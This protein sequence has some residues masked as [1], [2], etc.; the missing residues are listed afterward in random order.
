[1]KIKK[2]IKLKT[3]RFTRNQNVDLKIRAISSQTPNN[4]Y[5]TNKKENKEDE[6]FDWTNYESIY[7][8]LISYINLMIIDLS[9]EKEKLCE[10]LKDIFHAVFKISQEIKKKKQVIDNIK[11][12]DNNIDINNKQNSTHEEWNFLTGEIFYKKNN[13][14][15]INEKNNIKQLFEKRI[16]ASKN[17]DISKI[18]PFKIKV[19]M[20]RRK[21][22]KKERQYK[23]DQLNFLFRINEQNQLIDKLE[24]E[25]KINNINNL[26]Q[27]EL[28]QIKCFPDF[29]SIKDNFLK[30]NNSINHHIKIIEDNKEN[31]KTFNN[32]LNNMKF[33]NIINN[34]KNKRN[35]NLNDN[36]SKNLSLLNLQGKN[37]RMRLTKFA[38]FSLNDTKAK[39]EKIKFY[40]MF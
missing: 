14:N 37:Q 10:Y 8:N 32:N 24:N 4:F 20:L 35:L 31:E 6:L 7:N 38:S 12:E 21:F 16:N 19:D 2:I 30:S 13:N 28:S 5:H 3:P 11:N 23:I 36:F 17:H 15:L 34:Y 9:E 22:K 26:T 33:L 39:V 40:K 27:N 25:I 29:P 18:S 1:M